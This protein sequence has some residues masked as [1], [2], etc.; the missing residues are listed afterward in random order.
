M[1]NDNNFD[2]KN[3]FDYVWVLNHDKPISS[4][5]DIE[6]HLHIQQLLVVFQLAGH[7]P[8]GGFQLIVQLIDGLLQSDNTQLHRSNIMMVNAINVQFW[9]SLWQIGEMFVLI[10]CL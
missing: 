6:S 4:N 8:F 9:F 5:L 10:S 1:K 3:P 7:L 2:I